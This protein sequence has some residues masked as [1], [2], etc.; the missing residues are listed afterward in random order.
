MIQLPKYY[1]MHF[2]ASFTLA[3]SGYSQVLL[4]EK[5]IVLH[6]ADKVNSQ[7]DF[8][9]EVKL[10]Q[11]AQKLILLIDVKDDELIAPSG[12]KDADKV[13]IYFS[14]QSTEFVDYIYGQTNGVPRLFRQSSE[15]SSL[16][17]LKGFI[18]NADYPA[19]T[20]SK[21][22][23]LPPPDKLS[24]KIVPIGMV[25]FELPLVENAK[26]KMLL[27]ADYEPFEKLTGQ[28]MG[29]L[30]PFITYSFQK[31]IDGYTLQVNIEKE[32][33][34]FFEIPKTEAFRMMVDVY[35]F[36]SDHKK[37]ASVASLT[38]SREYQ[39][40]FYFKKVNL[41]DPLNFSIPGVDD[42]ALAKTNIKINGFMTKQGIAAYGELV[43]S[44]IY[45]PNIMSDADL[46]EFFF[47]HELFGFNTFQR[48]GFTI[49]LISYKAQ[50]KRPFAEDELMFILDGEVQSTKAFAYDRQKN[51]NF[52]NVPVLLPNNFIGIA[53]YDY[54]PE[55]H[56]GWS[57]CGTCSDEV[58][59][60]FSLRDV[61]NP[62]QVFTLGAKLRR[63]AELY[64]DED[65]YR[66][67]KDFDINW[68]EPGKRFDIEI[69]FK[70]DTRQKNLTLSYEI[71]EQL[72]VRKL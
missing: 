19:N 43:Q 69:I 37:Q 2:L 1:L 41:S 21:D 68:T 7:A 31:N 45:A 17:D 58:V 6:H 51:S 16:V 36:D 14:R 50:H 11:E 57:D 55:E 42:D 40:P 32:A 4:N 3:F 15:P 70:P 52:V 22:Y 10:T 33:L 63:N 20:V 35:D 25:G 30:S 13:E 59:S 28:S 53:L 5:L 27:R 18:Q 39:R 54:E 8:S 67:V 66:H 61:N 34:G 48:E 26:A 9:A 44:I 12:N 65:I 62:V 47:H 49:D 23:P 29:D 38:K 72:K 64:I 60:L 46:L 56:N 24:R 71:D